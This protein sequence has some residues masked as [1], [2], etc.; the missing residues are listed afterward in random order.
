MSGEK[1]ESL[2]A[3]AVPVEQVLFRHG[4]DEE[5]TVKEQEAAGPVEL[6]AG[7]VK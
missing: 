6:D 2:K 5:P 4:G 7:K 3:H 1:V